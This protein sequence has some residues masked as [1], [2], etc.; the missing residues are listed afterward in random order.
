MASV[1]LGVFLSLAQSVVA[2]SPT[3]DSEPQ[4]VLFHVA[5]VVGGAIVMMA[6]F[7][8]FSLVF[9][10]LSSCVPKPAECDLEKGRQDMAAS[11]PPSKAGHT[12]PSVEATQTPVDMLR[13][14]VPDRDLNGVVPQLETGDTTTDKEQEAEI[15]DQSTNND[16]GSL[17]NQSS[18]GEKAPAAQGRTV[19]LKKSSSSSSGGT[20]RGSTAKAGVSTKFSKNKPATSPA[21][22]ASPRSLGNAPKAAKKTQPA[23]PNR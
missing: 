7:Q 20:R 23:S 17:S 4:P 11:T 2:I 5:I 14:Q 13:I 8:C 22:S 10:K 15:S 16:G 1:R 9:K 18:T 12:P 3:T 6:A 21:K 19:K